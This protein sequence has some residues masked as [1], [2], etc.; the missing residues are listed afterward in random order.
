MNKHKI[1]EIAKFAGG[2][3]IILTAVLIML[4][5]LAH[6]LFSLGRIGA[7]TAGIIIVASIIGYLV[8]TFR[9]IRRSNT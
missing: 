3:I 6:Y 2:I 4:P 8:Y 5:D 9:T 7:Y 1:F